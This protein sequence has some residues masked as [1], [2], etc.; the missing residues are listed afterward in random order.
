VPQA[1]QRQDSSRVGESGCLCSKD[2]RTSPGSTQQALP[3]RRKPPEPFLTPSSLV[4]PEFVSEGRDGREKAVWRM[5]W[6]W[7]GE[8]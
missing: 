7:G 3:R 6:G 8:D 4:D 5:G 2:S 1:C